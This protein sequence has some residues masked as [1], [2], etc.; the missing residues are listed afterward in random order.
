MQIHCGAGERP[1]PRWA[2]RPREDNPLRIVIFGDFTGRANRNVSPGLEGRRAYEVDGGN[3]DR[4]MARLAPRLLLTVAELPEPV[5][6]RFEELDGFH[7]DSLWRRLPVFARFQEARRR[8]EDLPARERRP[9]PPPEWPAAEAPALAPGAGLLDQ[10]IAASSPGAGR[11]RPAP[12]EEAW[13]Q[14]IE[15]IVAPHVVPKPDPAREEMAG[16]LDAAAGECMVAVLR[17]PDFQALEAAWRSLWF[18]LSRLEAES[19]LR[20][21]IVD[22]ARE[23]LIAD[24]LRAPDLRAT[25]LYRLLVDEGE[26]A[27]VGGLYTFAP[28]A[29]DAALLERMA[30]LARAGGAAFVAGAAPRFAERL[31]PEE[32]QAWSALRR[33]PVAQSIGLTWPRLLLRLPYGPRTSSTDLLEF[34]EMPA[35]PAHEAYLWG[36]PAIAAVCALAGASNEFERLPVHTWRDAEGEPQMTPCAERWL[37]ADQALRLLELGVMPL[38]SIKGRDAARLLRLQS[39]ADPCAPLAGGARP[40]STIG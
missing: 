27:I 3:L 18:L 37:T 34:D 21:H 25:N 2:G 4:T 10:M 8:L 33:S 7:P 12:R 30:A 5:D 19:G 20:V 38:V 23:D 13:A 28:S 24:L 29:G 1:E 31:T 16:R 35:P 36:N 14:A 17:H 6:I 39:V 11:A 26:W 40:G 22:A 9:A 32:E 15:S